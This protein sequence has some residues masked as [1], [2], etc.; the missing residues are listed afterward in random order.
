YD[1]NSS[2]YSGEFTDAKRFYFV[3]EPPDPPPPEPNMDAIREAAQGKVCKLSKVAERSPQPSRAATGAATEPKRL[4]R[5]LT[6]ANSTTEP[7]ARSASSESS[8]KSKNGPRLS[9]HSVLQSS[10]ATGAAWLL[11]F[12]DVRPP[13]EIQFA[14]ERDLMTLMRSSIE[15][16]KLVYRAV[17][18]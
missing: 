8:A 11:H 10:T 16:G 7:K 4:R 1:R 2:I 12:R 5:Q 15:V 13:Q 9:P 17:A 14:L 6:D 3:L 18:K